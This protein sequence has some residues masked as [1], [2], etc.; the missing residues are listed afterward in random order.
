LVEPDSQI[1]YRD[2]NGR[3]NTLATLLIKEGCNQDRPVGV[4]MQRSIDAVVALLAALKANTPY[5][6][7][8]IS[9]PNERLKLLI[10]DAD[11][12]VILTHR[13]L[14][15]ALPGNVK[16]ISLDDLVL[17]GISP[18]LSAGIRSSEDL[19]YI[20]YTSG[21]TGAPKGVQGSHRAAINRFE[22]MWRTYPFTAGE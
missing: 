8:D 2:L 9:N 13:G 11:C 3:A 6:P 20:M 15:S 17:M 1:T 4:Y 18:G 10:G 5:V 19:A 21:S 7:L 22:W 14:A 12:K 16:T